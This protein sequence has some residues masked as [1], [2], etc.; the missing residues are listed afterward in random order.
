MSGINLCQQET[1]PAVDS[2]GA[3]IHKRYA[4][5]LVRG[6]LVPAEHRTVNPYVSFNEECG[7]TMSMISAI[8]MD[9][10]I[11]SFFKTISTSTSLF[12]GKSAHLSIEMG[13]D[14][15]FIAIDEKL[16]S[17]EL[18]KLGDVLEASRK[19][20]IQMPIEERFMTILNQDVL[21][22]RTNGKDWTVEGFISELR[23]CSSGFDPIKAVFE[24]QPILTKLDKAAVLFAK[25]AV[26]HHPVAKGVDSSDLSNEGSC[27]L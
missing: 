3:I 15:H 13:L 11:E 1:Y 24:A 8:I 17:V 2:D 22:A 23:D 9:D 16:S 25:S 10:F 5:S 14:Y 4:I 27:D 7:N 21:K 12:S 18:N 6:L 26:A 20:Y 19:A